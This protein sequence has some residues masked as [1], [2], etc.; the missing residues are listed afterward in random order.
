MTAM[1]EPRRL[2]DCHSHWSTE[3]GYFFRTPEALASQKQIWGTE[4]RYDSEE[5]MVAVFRKARARVILELAV[6]MWMSIDEIRDPA[7][8]VERLGGVASPRS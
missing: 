3:R 7:R 4:P 1:L 5:E 2:F 8:W 6:T